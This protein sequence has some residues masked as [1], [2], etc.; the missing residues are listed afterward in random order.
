[1]ENPEPSTIRLGKTE[2]EIPLIGTGVWAWGDRMVWGFGRDY[3]EQDIRGA[4]KA[5]LDSA[6]NFFDTAEAY[7]QGRS[8]RLLG[9]FIQDYLSNPD[10][11]PN[12]R[13][14]LIVATKFTPY[15]WR[16]WKG[17]LINAL[18]GSLKRLGLEYVDLYQIHFPLPPTPVEIWA[19]GLGDA[20]DLGL[21]K[22]VGVSNYNEQQM[23]QTHL[24]LRKRGFDLASNQVEYH[25][26][27]RKIEFNGLLKACQDLGIT[28]IA[29]SPLAQGVLTGKYTPAT[30]P[31]GIRGRRYHR[32]YLAKVQP[33]LRILKD[34]GREHD[35]KSPA[36]VALN[37]VIC[38]GAIPIP[39]AKTER[40]VREN[41]GALNW[42]LTEAEVAI[43]DEA[44]QNL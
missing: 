7:G 9:S 32:S 34:I 31:P 12:S 38:K 23:R 18:K 40:Q 19:E 21:A 42:R 41:S 25:L 14:M 22:S 15:P 11:M 27:N 33:M 37:W 36:Q 29:Y 4:F 6:I 5:S 20:I 2:L 35:G 17:T 26:L 10:D 13:E 39:G 30:P 16:L 44:S 43:L 3:A 8:E 1:M 28:P 24:T